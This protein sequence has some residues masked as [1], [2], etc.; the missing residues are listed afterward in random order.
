MAYARNK[1][2][3]EADPLTP[4]KFFAKG[5]FVCKKKKNKSKVLALKF[6]VC[7]IC[8]IFMTPI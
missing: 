2:P 1:K 6:G 4:S 7:S 5:Y 8:R 3:G